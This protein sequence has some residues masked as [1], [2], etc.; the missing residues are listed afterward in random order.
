MNKLEVG[1]YVRFD[2]VICQIEEVEEDYLCFDIGFYDHWNELTYSMKYKDFVEEYKPKFANNII[3][4]IE[5]G[6]IVTTNVIYH[7][8]E[9]KTY[10]LKRINNSVELD[11]L[12]SYVYH[13]KRVIKSIVTK[14]QFSSMEYRLGE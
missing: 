2:N 5:V 11:T 6:D 7:G 4:L 10:Y 1:M 3:D 14:E 13:N 9:K 12:K 8:L